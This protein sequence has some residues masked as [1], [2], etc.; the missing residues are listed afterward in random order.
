MKQTSPKGACGPAKS[1][2]DR[3]VLEGVSGVKGVARKELIALAETHM[4]DRVR[5]ALV[6]NFYLSCLLPK[7]FFSLMLI[8][9]AQQLS[10]LPLGALCQTERQRVKSLN[11]QAVV[12]PKQR[13]GDPQVS[14]I[15]LFSGTLLSLRSRH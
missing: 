10:G 15:R 5:T 6:G 4:P 13:S 1:L 14:N 2:E 3:H 8:A 7:V 12:H 9:D 11:A